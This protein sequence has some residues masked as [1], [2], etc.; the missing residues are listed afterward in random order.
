MLPTVVHR[1]VALD[2]DLPGF[3]VHLRDDDM[4]AEREGEI[5]RLPEVRRHHAGFGVGR[6][7]HGAVGRAGDLGER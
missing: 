3:A 2:L 7:L 5:R 6:Q 4:G 1:D